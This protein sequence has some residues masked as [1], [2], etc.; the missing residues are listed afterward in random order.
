MGRG[1]KL[2]TMEILHVSYEGLLLK[3]YFQYQAVP[4][5]HCFHGNPDTACL[6]G[7]A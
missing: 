4:A 5:G 3:L 6:S 2:V 7:R 1:Y